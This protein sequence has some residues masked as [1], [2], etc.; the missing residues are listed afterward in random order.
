MLLPAH[1]DVRIE[2]GRRHT[3][4]IGFA[5]V[6]AIGRVGDRQR[7]ALRIT[8]R[9]DARGGQVRDRRL[10]Q[11][12]GLLFVVGGG[13]QFGSHDDPM[14]AVHHGLRVVAIVV[15]SSRR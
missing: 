6:A 11:R 1:G 13:G 4:D 3:L 10:R 14:L 5:E 7:L 15:S 12:Y 2:A 9:L 8:R